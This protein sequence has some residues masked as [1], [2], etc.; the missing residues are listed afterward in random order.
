MEELPLHILCR[1]SAIQPELLRHLIAG[2]PDAL[3][4]SAAVRADAKG[5]VLSTI[6]SDRQLCKGAELRLLMLVAR[7]GGRTVRHHCIYCAPTS[8]SRLRF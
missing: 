6:V 5:W 7:V 3:Y 2:N 4:A 1:N 8:V